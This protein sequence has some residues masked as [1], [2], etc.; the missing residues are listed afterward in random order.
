M[1]YDKIDLPLPLFPE[2]QFEKLNN[3]KGIMSTVLIYFFLNTEDPVVVRR[4]IA[5]SKQVADGCQTA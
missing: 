3:G 4:N 2:A 1:Y 5:K